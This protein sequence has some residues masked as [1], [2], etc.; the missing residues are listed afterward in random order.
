MAKARRRGAGGGGRAGHAAVELA[1]LLP[2][3]M[4]VCLAAVDYSRLMY[5]TV[6]LTE[7]ARSG[8]EWAANSALQASAPYLTAQD[9]AVADGSNLG[10]TASAVTMS[11]PSADASGNSVY[12][13]TVTYTFT[14]IVNYPGIPSSVALSR[15]VVMP[16][17][18]P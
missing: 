1:L 5:A 17:A 4:F 11:G 12:T 2:F 9:A 15:K 6:T 10:L 14:T 13:A 16:A 8:A 7:C 3:L 18:P